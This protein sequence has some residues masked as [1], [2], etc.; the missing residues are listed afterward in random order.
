MPLKVFCVPEGA[1]QTGPYEALLNYY[2]ISGAPWPDGSC[3]S[4]PATDARP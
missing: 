3:R 4:S 2:G 1:K